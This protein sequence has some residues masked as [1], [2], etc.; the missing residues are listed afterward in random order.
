MRCR[1]STRQL[2]RSSSKSRTVLQERGDIDRIPGKLR[3]SGVDADQS[4]AAQAEQGMRI[5][6][7]EATRLRGPDRATIERTRQ[8][9]QLL[10]GCAYQW[11]PLSC[12][13]LRKK[14]PTEQI[15]ADAW[16]ATLA[17]GDAGPMLGQVV[18]DS[19]D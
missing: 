4:L 12:G 13:T 6:A 8:Q 16:S 7:R 2:A 9:V 3:A 11:D 18:A 5:I 1:P 15:R 17:N 14:T 10:H 19:N